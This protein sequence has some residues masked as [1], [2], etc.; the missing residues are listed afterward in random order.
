M[1]FQWQFDVPDEVDQPPAAPP[2]VERDGAMWVVLAIGLVALLLWGWNTARQAQER[3]AA[4]LAGELQQV[5][6]LERQ[7]VL[8]G[9][10][11]LF[12]AQQVDDPAWIALQFKPLHQAFTR[13]EREVTRAEETGEEA[14]ANVSWSDAAGAW[15]R[16]VFFVREGERWRRAPSGERF[17]G[18]DQ[19]HRYAWGEL[20]L[21]ASDARWADQIARF[22]ATR[23]C[24]ADQVLTVRIAPASVAASRLA[25]AVVV[26]SPRLIGLDAAGEPGGPF[27]EL[28]AAHLAPATDPIRYVV[29]DEWALRY[30]RLAADYGQATGV[31]VEIRP[32]GDYPADPAAWLDQV[33]GAQLSPTVGLITAGVIYD[34]T[35]LVEADPGFAAGDFYAQIWAAAW[36]RERMWQ[37]PAA[38]SLPII[39]YDGAAFAAAGLPEPAPGWSWDD[40]NTVA[41][42]LQGVMGDLSPFRGPYW[43]LLDEH[44]DALRGVA[45]N[46]GRRCL[47]PP[48]LFALEAGDLERAWR[49][50]DEQGRVFMPDLSGLDEATR[51]LM[52]LRMKRLMQAAMWV[53]HAVEFEDHLTRIDLGLAPLPRAGSLGGIGEPG[54]VGIAPLHV[55]GH[56]ISGASRQPERVWAWIRHLSQ[57]PPDAL[58]EVP[59]RPSVAAAM[60]FWQ[61][62]PAPLSAVLTASFP[63]ARPVMIGE[64]GWLRWDDHPEPGASPASRPAWF[65]LAEE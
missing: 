51:A 36:W 59:A 31:A 4:G 29:P 45:L 13:A 10:G 49:W 24:C 34:L 17:W 12:L 3:A 25:N 27:W 32:R 56:I 53:G 42:R 50:Y 14:W 43:G 61:R 41:P 48:C 19:T 6:E 1:G 21:S 8:A 5:L 30:E 52:A 40:L 28:L 65:P 38:A 47:E 22:V 62:L 46:F 44:G 23:A 9:D 60:G 26:P 11:E 63:L 18:P 54:Q 20:I 64:A 37:V 57:Q 16:L 2:P 55:T 15:Q 39:Y 35:P 58:R 33:D 7:A